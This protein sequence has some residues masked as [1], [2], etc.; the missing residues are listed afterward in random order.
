M[1]AKKTAF[2]RVTRFIHHPPKNVRSKKIVTAQGV[3]IQKSVREFRMV[4]HDFDALQRWLL[5]PEYLSSSKRYSKCALRAGKN[6]PKSVR[7]WKIGAPS[8]DFYFQQELI[9]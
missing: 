8:W 6:S 7:A 2:F 1:T 9:A 5:T 4:L 3:R